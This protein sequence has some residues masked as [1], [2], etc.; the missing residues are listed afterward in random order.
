M[1]LTAIDLSA[2]RG[3]EI[4]FHRL[5]F[6]LHTGQ[7][8][9]ITGPNGIGK[10]TLLRIVAGFLDPDE[11]RVVIEESG[12]EFPV[13]AACHYLGGLNAMK[14]HLTVQENLAFWTAFEGSPKMTPPE[15]LGAVELSGIDHLPFGVL[16]TGQKRR[17]AI[18]RLLLSS[19]PI[20]LLDEP[21]SGLDR[22][23][24]GIFSRILQNHLLQDGMAIA[25]THLPL[26]VEEDSNIAMSDFL[27]VW[28][29]NE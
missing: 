18:A 23:A 19:Q 25:A 21:T 6:T 14:P 28:E 29:E 11:G 15:A 2:R 1:Q 26:G 4:L 8:M 9:T 13:S 5:G 24:S 20:W 3:D 16:S 27:P 17:V 7:L 10:S 22:Q 12:L